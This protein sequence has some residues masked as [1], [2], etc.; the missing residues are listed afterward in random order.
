MGSLSWSEIVT[1]VLAILIVFGPKRLPELA[2]R[3]GQLT[4]KARSAARALRDEFQAEYGDTVAPLRDVRD[5]LRAARE[6]LRSAATSAATDL[7]GVA[8]DA[9]EATRKSNPF[10]DLKPV[11]DETAPE[12]GSGDEPPASEAAG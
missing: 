3:A 1:I 5:D 10:A 4:A 9:E 8:K 11:E 12:D 6:D 7:E 2:R